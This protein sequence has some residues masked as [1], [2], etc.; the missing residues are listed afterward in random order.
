MF[1]FYLYHI[2]YYHFILKLKRPNEVD[3]LVFAHVFTLIKSNL[4]PTVQDIANTIKQFPKLIEHAS[5]IDSNYFNHALV[6]PDDDF[7]VV[8]SISFQRHLVELFRVP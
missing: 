7:E 3:A 4:R 1:F 6:E 5:K 8:G 2:Y